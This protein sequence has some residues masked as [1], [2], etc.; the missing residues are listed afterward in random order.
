MHKASLISHSTKW[1]RVMQITCEATRTSPSSDVPAHTRDHQLK[2]Y[3]TLPCQGYAP[4]DFKLPLPHRVQRL[5]KSMP[6]ILSIVSKGIREKKQVSLKS[7][8]QS[9]Q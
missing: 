7:N 4:T 2:E 8:S 3:T 9:V 5:S 1:I 6:K